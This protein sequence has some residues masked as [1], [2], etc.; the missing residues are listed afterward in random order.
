MALLISITKKYFRVQFMSIN[1]NAVAYLNRHQYGDQNVK[2]KR[3]HSQSPAKEN[4]NY[5]FK[6]EA[7][8]PMTTSLQRMEL[9]EK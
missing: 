6:M 1:T 7:W 2:P 4:M 8:D 9:I 5:V 3:A